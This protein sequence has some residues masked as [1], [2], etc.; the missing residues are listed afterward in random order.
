MSHR[1]SPSEIQN[2]SISLE[3]PL[4]AA[5]RRRAKERRQSFSAYVSLLIEK[6]V[7]RYKSTPTPEKAEVVG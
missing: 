7:K 1:E 6:D 3:S 2:T 4:L 5:G